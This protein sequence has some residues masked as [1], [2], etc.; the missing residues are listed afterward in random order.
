MMDD[1]LYVSY[2]MNGSI[3]VFANG[4]RTDHKLRNYLGGGA[5]NLL[6][7][8]DEIWVAVQNTDLGGFHCINETLIQ[9]PTPFSVQRHSKDLDLLERHDFQDV[10]FGGASVAYGDGKQIIIG[11]YKA[12]RIAVFIPQ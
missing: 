6:V 2:R 7:V 1:R 12:D 8:G 5:D 4:N 9:C 10:A 11:A 3:G